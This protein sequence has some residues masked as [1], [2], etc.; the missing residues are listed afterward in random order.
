MPLRY[1]L[2]LFFLAYIAAA[3]F[4]RS[5]IVRKK[6]GIN[7]VVFKGSDSPHDYIGRIF[8]LLFA[9]IAI[10][11]LIYSF[12]PRAYPYFMPIDWLERL[13]IKSIGVALLL[14]SLVWTVVAQAQMAESWRIGIDQEHKTPLVKTGVFGF[15]RNPIFLGV[16]ITLFGLFFVIPNALTLLILVTGIV[17][18]GVQVRLEEEFLTMTHGEEYI[19][20]RRAVRRWL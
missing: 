8:K 1:F 2:P 19:E 11:I 20:Y 12:S 6:T 7:P 17:V 18:I 5:F 9:L 14:L 13:W 3:F 4:W 15:S 10:V 16:M